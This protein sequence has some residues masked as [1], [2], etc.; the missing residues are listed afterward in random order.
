MKS[1][2]VEFLTQPLEPNRL[3]NAVEQSLQDARQRW[4]LARAVA[5]A[6]ARVA[7]LDKR[8]H[9]VVRLVFNGFLNKEIA[10]YLNLAL[11]T[12]KV[13]RAMKKLGA[14]NAPEMVR[15]AGLAGMCNEEPI[16]RPE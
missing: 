14:G 6:K 2:A 7:S 1:E 8:E 12:I 15:V 11:V 5:V 9:E 4:D 13:Y 3:L 16:P 10:D